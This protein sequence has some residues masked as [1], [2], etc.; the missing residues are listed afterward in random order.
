MVVFIEPH[1]DDF[2]LSAGIYSTKNPVDEVIT[3]F[4]SKKNTGGS[5]ALS[6][7]LG[8]TYIEL[9]F[10]NIDWKNPSVLFEP[11]DLLN[12]LDPLL[13]KSNLILTVLGVGNPAHFFLREFIIKNYVKKTSVFFFRDFPHSYDSTKLGNLPFSQYI[14]D[15]KKVSSI[16]STVEFTSKVELFKKYYPSQKSLLWFEREQFDNPVP[17]EVYEYTGLSKHEAIW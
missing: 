8:K 10:P 16:G 4:K 9:G 5:R 13:L 3:V 15:F 2:I 17:E 11:K 14:R 6:K 7:D 12:A 1:Y